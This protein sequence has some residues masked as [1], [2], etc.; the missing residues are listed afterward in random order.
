VSVVALRL[1]ASVSL[2]LPL[3]LLILWVAW[4]LLRRRETRVR[5]WLGL[6]Y[7]LLAASLA[8]P[9]IGHLLATGAG[10]PTAPV[11]IWSGAG[12]EQGEMAVTLTVAGGG[13]FEEPREWTG[14]FQPRVVT[15]ALAA[16][17]LASV[18]GLGRL[19]RTWWRLRRDCQGL[20]VLRRRGR[21]RICVSGG[22]AV[23]F[24][25]WTGTEAYVVVP[26]ALLADPPRLHLT[27][28]H[29][30]EHLRQRDTTWVYALELVRALFPWHP[31]THAWCTFLG[32]LQEYACDQS[33]LARGAPLEAYADCLIRAAAPAP[34]KLSPSAI[35]VGL[36]GGR[37]R[38]LRRRI[39]MLV[40]HTARHSRWLAPVAAV[41]GVALLGLAA[42]QAETAVADRRVTRAQAESVS[43][44]VAER[45][46]FRVEI[47]ETVLEQLNAMVGAEEARAWWRA[48]LERGAGLRPEIDAVL[49]RHGVPVE[50][51]AVA[52]VESG[53]RNLPPSE[54]E[55]RRLGAGVWQFIPGTA[56]HFGLRVDAATDQRMDVS[57]A[58]DAA[59]RYLAELHAEFEDWP[60]AIA[61]Y[62]HG[63]GMLRK[64]IAESGTRNASAL[65][66]RG[67]LQPYSSQVLAAVLLMEKPDLV[68]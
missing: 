38:H 6:G 40:N 30:L 62:T 7:A 15:L 36:G 20:P 64:V 51:A 35:A 37:R 12:S 66:E 18:A 53:F 29:E 10:E 19:A 16:L 8:A 46:G 68:R 33:L 65:V 31:A 54:D 47:D 17:L 13:L 45:S 2:L 24:S 57:L 9:V 42:V 61:G 23:P 41:A 44:A 60:L 1:I 55:P 67:V 58:T 27:V 22:G 26:V 25:V 49:Q 48:S 28:R 4:T 5:R 11:K 52:L 34:P 14:L 32:R 43:T 63:A 56:R 3:A 21:L 50:L 39:E 59:A